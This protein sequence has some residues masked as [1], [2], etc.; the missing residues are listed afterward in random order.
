MN[1]TANRTLEKMDE[2]NANMD[3]LLDH[4][5]RY[6]FPLDIISPSDKKAPKSFKVPSFS[7]N[8]TAKKNKTQFHT[9]KTSKLETYLDLKSEVA[10]FLVP[11]DLEKKISPSAVVKF[12]KQDSLCQTVDSMIESK[13]EEMNTEMSS[14]IEENKDLIV[15]KIADFL[16]DIEDAKTDCREY[17]MN[18]AAQDYLDSQISWWEFKR[19]KEL[20]QRKVIEK[21]KREMNPHPCQK[22][23][24]GPIESPQEIERLTK[25]LEQRWDS[26][27]S[28]WSDYYSKWEQDKSLIFNQKIRKDL[29]Q[30]NLEDDRLMA[31]Y[32]LKF[33]DTVKSLRLLDLA[34]PIFPLDDPVKLRKFLASNEKGMRIDPDIEISY[35]ETPI[36]KIHLLQDIFKRY[37]YSANSKEEK[38]EIRRFITDA[39]FMLYEQQVIQLKIDA[40]SA[41]QE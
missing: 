9:I 18:K 39:I 27:N 1:K 12:P 17:E 37:F 31:L 20:K 24:S 8:D 30:I 2:S 35:I 19:K 32:R 36:E 25:L 11:E 6:A 34:K 40:S 22:R 4:C 41:E 14:Y 33:E 5:Y 13:V 3:R 10:Y 28:R 29:L 38:L 23:K 16:R 26:F 7:F 15:S 21:L